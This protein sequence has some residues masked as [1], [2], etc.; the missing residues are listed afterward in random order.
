MNDN[1]K[2][3]VAGLMIDASDADIEKLSLAVIEHCAE[4]EDSWADSG[5][6]AT[7]GLRLKDHFGVQD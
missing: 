5:K 3:L 4:L 7:F 6:F 2:D 1:L